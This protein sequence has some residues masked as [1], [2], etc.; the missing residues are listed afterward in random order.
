MRRQRMQ[1][2]EFEEDGVVFSEQLPGAVGFYRRIAGVFEEVGFVD[3]GEPTLQ[4]ELLAGSDLPTSYAGCLPDMLI[5][6]PDGSK[7]L[8]AIEGEP[9]FNESEEVVAFDRRNPEVC[10]P[11]TAAP[12]SAPALAAAAPGTCPCK[13]AR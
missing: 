13:T 11:L 4:A 5:F 2:N 12:P 3:F 8:V 1:G 9:T 6:T 7:V 10:P